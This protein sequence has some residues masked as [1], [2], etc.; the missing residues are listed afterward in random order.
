MV[1]GR[2]GVRWVGTVGGLEC[3]GA[4]VRT[5]EGRQEGTS[6]RRKCSI[7]AKDSLTFVLSESWPRGEVARVANSNRGS[8][9]WM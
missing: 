6:D 4:C 1:A 5:R 7:G 8:S 2:W 3:G 9:S